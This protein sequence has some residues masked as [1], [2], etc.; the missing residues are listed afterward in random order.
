MLLRYIFSIW[1][2][3]SVFSK[4]TIYIPQTES[5][6]TVLPSERFPSIVLSVEDYEDE[7]NAAEDED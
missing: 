3:I 6:F 5:I 1:C 4:T 2:S 7:E